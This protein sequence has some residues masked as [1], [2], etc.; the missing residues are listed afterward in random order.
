[1]PPVTGDV[2]KTTISGSTKNVFISKN[3]GRGKRRP[4]T[5]LLQTPLGRTAIRVCVRALIPVIDRLRRRFDIA[6]V[7]VV[8][9][10]GLISAETMTELEARRRLH[11]LGVR[12]LVLDDPSPFA[13]RAAHAEEAQQRR[14]RLRGQDD[15]AGR[16]SNIVCR[17]HQE[18]EKDAADAPRSWLRW[19]ASSP[20]ATRQGDKAL[21]G[22]TGYRRYLKTIGDDHFAI[23]RAKIEEDKKL[24]GFSCCAPT[25]ISIRS[26]P[27][28]ATSSYGRWSRPSAPPTRPIFHKL[29]ETIRGHVGR[30]AE[31]TMKRLPSCAISVSISE[32]R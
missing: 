12:E 31:R 9:D 17:N 4:T 24:D 15:D 18:A 16:A 21:V 10:R 19:S 28:S 1:M 30:G 14:G 23:D 32:S 13:V 3:D 8:A 11:I 26:R 5:T 7:C 2:L 27:C 20:R 29:D 6:R 25:P 22:N